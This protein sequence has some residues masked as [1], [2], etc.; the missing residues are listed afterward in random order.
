MLFLPLEYV[1]HQ[2]ESVVAHFS[3][4]QT[5]IKYSN[6]KNAGKTVVQERKHKENIKKS[7][8]LQ[9]AV[10]RMQ[11]MFTLFALPVKIFQSPNFEQLVLYNG[12]S[13][14]FESFTEY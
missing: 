9:L 10:C 7:S 8:T 11:M 5:K 6:I 12:M 4:L 13:F 14:V 3:I 2:V 1:T